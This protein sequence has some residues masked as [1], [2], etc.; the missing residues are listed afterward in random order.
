M[1]LGSWWAVD[2]KIM[3]TCFILSIDNKPHGTFREV[4]YLCSICR[5][6]GSI[7][8]ACPSSLGHM[9]K[10]ETETDTETDGGNGN[11]QAIIT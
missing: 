3:V 11:T 1:Q 4:Y 9:E 2:R 7:K 6:P 10:Q 8:A 5:P